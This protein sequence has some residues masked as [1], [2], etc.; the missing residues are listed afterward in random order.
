MKIND[1]WRIERGAD[2]FVVVELRKGR[3]PKTGES[4][5]TEVRTYHPTLGQCA[6]K[7]TRT[8]TLESMEE[9]DIWS[10]VIEI[11][12]ST[13]RLIRALESAAKEPPK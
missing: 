1:Q 3:N 8:K 11:N 2:C 10:A 4:T 12:A 9:D 13:N 6:K 5:K 7:I